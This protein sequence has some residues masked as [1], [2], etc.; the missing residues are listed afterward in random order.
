MCFSPDRSRNPSFTLQLNTVQCSDSNMQCDSKR[1]LL[2]GPHRR[3][4]DHVVPAPLVQAD[5]GR[6]LPGL[7]PPG[8]QDRQGQDTR[9][10]PGKPD[11]IK[12]IYLISQNNFKIDSKGAASMRRRHGEGLG[13]Q[14]DHLRPR[15]KPLHRGRSGCVQ[16]TIS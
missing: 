10:R 15:H 7:P 5:Q 13:L 6:L 1:R 14:A 4:G 12:Y 11:L 2:W 9:V 8:L 16:V 3:R